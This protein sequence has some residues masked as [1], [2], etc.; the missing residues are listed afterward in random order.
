[1]VARFKGKRALV[2]GGARGIGAAV[3]RALHAEGA[4]IVVGAKTESSMKSFL[5]RHQS[6]RF[7][8]VASDLSSRRQCHEVVGEALAM[9]GG[10]DVLVNSAGIFADIDLEDVSQEHWDDNINVNLGGVFFC[11]QAAIPA[12]VESRGAIVNVA[13]DAGLIGY[14]PAPAYGAAKSGV[15]NLTQTLAY[16]YAKSV[17]VNCVCPGNVATEMLLNMAAQTP[18]PEEYLAAATNRS[19]MRRMATPEEIAEAILYFASDAAGFT[20]GVAMPIDGGGM[21]GY[22]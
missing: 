1:M 13:S 21:S 7:L 12:L 5:D 14:G 4:T 20:T 22:D 11:C 3:A 16:R 9:L 10:L 8:G 6:E 15:V 19:P 18:N 17:R 2:T